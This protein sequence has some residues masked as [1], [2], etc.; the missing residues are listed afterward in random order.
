[1]TSAETITNPENRATYD[2]N[3]A[4]ARRARIAQAAAGLLV[5]G[6]LLLANGGTALLALERGAS[7]DVFL[8]LVAGLTL[9]FGAGLAAWVNWAFLA[10]IHAQW[11]DSRLLVSDEPVVTIDQ[12]KKKLIADGAFAAAILLAALSTVA[13]P[14]AA[15]LLVF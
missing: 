9:A 10:L 5:V 13:L 3:L 7:P 8:T 15:V 14:L 11:A 2:Y 1:M 12:G 6:A 4:A